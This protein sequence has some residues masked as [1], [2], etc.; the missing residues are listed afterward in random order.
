MYYNN[1]I[2]STH[3]LADVILNVDMLGLIIKYMILVEFHTIIF[4]V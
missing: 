1:I 2:T 4:L 3:N